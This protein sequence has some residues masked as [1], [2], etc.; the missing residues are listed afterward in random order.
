MTSPLWATVLGTV[1][2]VTGLFSMSLPA[3]AKVLGVLL[4][5]TAAWMAMGIVRRLTGQAALGV[6]AGIILAVEPTFAFTTVSGMEAPLFASLSLAACWALVSGRLRTAGVLLGLAAVSRPE[7]F[8]LVFLAGISTVGRRLWQRER[9]EL[10]N[11]EDLKELAQLLLPSVVLGGAWA[12]YNVT[13]NGTLYPNTYLAKHQDMGL[14]PLGN[15]WNTMRGYFHNLSM[16][17]G[18]AAIASGIAVA[19]GAVVVL[20]Q[21]RFPGAP[22]ALFPLAMTWAV[23]ANFPLISGAW[24]FFT[25]R[26]LD[27]VIPFLVIMFVAGL[28]AVWRKFLEWR[29]TRAPADPQ[30]AHV[31]NFGLNVIFATL[32]VLPFIAFLADWQRLPEDYSWNAKNINEVNVKMAMWVRENTPPEA[33]IAVGDAGGTMRFFGERYVLDL[34]GLNSHEAIGRPALEVANEARPDYLI[35]YRSIY[36]D[37]WVPGTPV[38][39]V[40]TRRNTILGGNIMRV[41][42]ADYSAQAVYADQSLPVETD[43]ASSGFTVIDRVD[44]GNVSAPFKWSEEAHAYKIEGGGV[45]VEREFRSTGGGIVKDDARTYSV[46][47]QFTVNS[48]AGQR[49]AILKRYD[50]G[51]LGRVRVIA[52]GQEAG[53]WQLPP[54]DVFFG[55]DMFIVPPQLI[56]RDKTTLRFEVIPMPGAPSG[57]SFYYWVLV[58]S[59]VAPKAGG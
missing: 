29:A 38:F 16:F 13:V 56:T 24:N 57:N 36:F 28:H 3:T 11:R 9:L 19:A 43:T 8:V 5:I 4:G 17:A 45:T 47:E 55:E 35:A 59:D 25:R 23:A 20:R 42:R 54:K 52:D 22:L 49:L 53:V 2:K 40:E 50:A 44:T 41:Y 7:G 31:F 48:V 14:I 37:S 15:I 6:A 18:V 39:E 27:A 26:Y 21:Y 58:D 32:V 1:W 33:R 12:A 34:V 46:A 10:V 30:E 51:T